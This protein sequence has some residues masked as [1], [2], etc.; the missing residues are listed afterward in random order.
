MDPGE[1]TALRA[2]FQ[3]LREELSRQL[4]SLKESAKPVAPDNAL[5]RLTRMDAMQS[6]QIGQNALRQVT[7]QLTGIDHALE[8]F[9]AP[10][11]GLCAECG[12][13]I[14]L[15]RLRAMP[16]ARHCINCV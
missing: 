4:P 14:P 1:K 2:P 5:G 9:D 7:A 3:A 15:G 10:D 8:R 11:F 6:Q 12:A 16:G 13:P